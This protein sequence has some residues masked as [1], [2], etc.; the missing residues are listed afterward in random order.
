LDTD[1]STLV[2]GGSLRE[3]TPTRQRS[4]IGKVPA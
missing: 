1:K 3:T 2:L 4:C